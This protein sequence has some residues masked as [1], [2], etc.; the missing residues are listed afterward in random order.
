VVLCETEIY[1]GRVRFDA[2]GDGLAEVL[3]AADRRGAA[4]RN[5]D[6]LKY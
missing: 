5:A 1:V 4:C 6:S 2:R 3:R